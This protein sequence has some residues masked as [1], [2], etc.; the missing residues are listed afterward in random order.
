MDEYKSS[1]FNQKLML[2]SDYYSTKYSRI[3]RAEGWKN[4][5]DKFS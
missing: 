4:F 3:K 5:L 2:Q 1:N